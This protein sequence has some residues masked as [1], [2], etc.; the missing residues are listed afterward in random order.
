MIQLLLAADSQTAIQ[1]WNFK[2]PG[3]ADEVGA[4]PILAAM[5]H[6]TTLEFEGRTV[7]ID[8]RVQTCLGCM[9]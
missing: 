4:K 6:L 7:S 9:C 2:E 5:W 3:P 1:V 8:D